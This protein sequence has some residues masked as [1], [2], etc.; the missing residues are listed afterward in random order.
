MA[1]DNVI[2]ITDQGDDDRDG[3]SEAEAVLSWARAR[4]L[5]KQ[6]G[7]GFYV[8]NARSF[9]RLAREVI[10]HE[11]LADRPQPSTYA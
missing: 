7:N 5:S 4:E 9:E 10:H 11:G 3:S 6:T 8:P 2:W 1:I